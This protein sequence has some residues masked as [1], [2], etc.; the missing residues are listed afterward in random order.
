MSNG[1]GGCVNFHLAVSDAKRPREIYHYT[2]TGARQD[3]FTR[4]AVFSGG[5]CFWGDR[6][7]NQKKI[8]SK[9]VNVEDVI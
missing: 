6:E 7:E 4:S 2:L 1:D 8:M 3:R 5:E 9:R